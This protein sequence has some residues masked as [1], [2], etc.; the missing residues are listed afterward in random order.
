MKVSWRLSNVSLKLPTRSDKHTT[1]WNRINWVHWSRSRIQGTYWRRPHWGLP[2]R[3][4]RCDGGER[5]LASSS[6]YRLRLAAVSESRAQLTNKRWANT[7][8]RVHHVRTQ[9]RSGGDCRR[10]GFRARARRRCRGWGGGQR[11]LMPLVH[12]SSSCDR[13]TSRHWTGHQRRDTT[14]HLSPVNTHTHIRS[15]VNTGNFIACHFLYT[16]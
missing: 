10:D 5:R 12:C 7:T 11:P 13:R 4:R 3:R 15:P 9:G 2:T 8:R 16:T 1:V 6:F 14:L